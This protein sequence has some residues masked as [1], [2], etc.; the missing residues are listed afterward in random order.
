MNGN[1]DKIA[2]RAKQASNSETRSLEMPKVIIRH[3]QPSKLDH[4]QPGTKCHVLKPSKDTVDI[5]LQVSQQEDD[6]VWELIIE[7]IVVE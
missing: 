1:S 4:A 3:S 2:C 6:P 5:Y 7:G